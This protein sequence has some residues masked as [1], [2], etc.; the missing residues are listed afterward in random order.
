MRCIENSF[1]YLWTYVYPRC[2]VLGGHLYHT[3]GH[4]VKGNAESCFSISLT[5]VIKIGTGVNIEKISKEDLSEQESLSMFEAVGGDTL[6]S[7]DPT[8]WSRS[9]ADH[10]LW[11]VIEYHDF[12]SVI[13][14]L[15]QQRQNALK[16]IIGSN[17]EQVVNTNT[18]VILFQGDRTP[19]E[20]D[21]GKRKKKSK[22]PEDRLVIY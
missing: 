10:A 11:R 22:T 21:C 9:V 13:C 7:R 20:L 19:Y 1:C 5:R 8:A 16:D 18:K 15:S 4:R 6:V 12:E 3:E 17:A 14:L 2:V